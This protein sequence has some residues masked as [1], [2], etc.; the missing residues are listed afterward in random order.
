MLAQLGIDAA[1][2]IT[3]GDNMNGIDPLET[4]GHPFMMNNAHPDLIARLPSVPR[5]GNNFE[6]GVAHPL[7]KRFALHDEIVSHAPRAGV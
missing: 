7:R 6:A 5:I 4:A 1:G 3:F 2:C